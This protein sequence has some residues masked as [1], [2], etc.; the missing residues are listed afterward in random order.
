MLILGVKGASL[1][2]MRHIVPRLTPVAGF[3]LVETLVAVALLVAVTVGPVSL[4]GQSLFSSSFSRN[5]LIA[6]NLAQEGVELFRAIR[7]NNIL[8]ASLK[9]ASPP[10]W[11]VNPDGS[12]AMNA[13]YEIDVMNTRNLVCNG[14]SINTP[15]PFTRTAITCNTP[16][17]VDNLFGRYSYAGGMASKFTRCVRVCSPPSFG[18]PC[19]IAADPDIPPG[20]QME[21]IS[22]VSWMERGLPKSITE[23]DRI[24]NWH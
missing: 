6:Y 14:S 7:E 15:Q 2:R 24:Y 5:D 1:L 19:T 4:I 11:N 20:D 3:T 23:R 10:A 8:C 9:G 22:T 13:Y 16:L 21:I 17:L 18:G 12:G